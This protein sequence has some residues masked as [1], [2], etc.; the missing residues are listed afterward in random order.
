MRSPETTGCDG[1]AAVRPGF[2]SREVSTLPSL[3]GPRAVAPVL[4]PPHFD[5]WTL[6]GPL[7]FAHHLPEEA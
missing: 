2:E 5:P 1:H 7:P 6:T 4:P 3:L